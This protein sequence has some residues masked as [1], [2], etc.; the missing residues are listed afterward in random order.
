M[1]KSLNRA[2]GACELPTLPNATVA[3]RRAIVTIVT[4]DYL[5]WCRALFETVQTAYR[6]QRACLAYLIGDLP[7]GVTADALGFDVIQVEQ[8]GFGAFDDMAFRY[9]AFE[10]VNA[11]KPLIIK[12]ALDS[13]QFEEV[14]Y[15]DSDMIV[16][17]PLDEVDRALSDGATFM[18]TSHITTPH[19]GEF[20]PTNRSILRAGRL[21]A[22][23]LAARRHPEVSRFLS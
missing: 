6:G 23:F 9:A 2:Q 15:L 18:A 11:L 5:F 19:Q 8:L 4:K 16:V 12:H 21:N 17:S 7:S 10:L 22:G 14:V 13:L 1:P 3:P 20:H